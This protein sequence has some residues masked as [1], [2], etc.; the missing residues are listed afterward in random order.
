MRGRRVLVPLVVGTLA[1]GLFAVASP[2]RSDQAPSRLVDRTFSCEAAYVGGV[3][4][5]DV[6]AH[7]RSGRRGSSWRQPAFASVST[8]VSGSAETVVRNELAW[9]TSGRPSADA[10]IA[11]TIPGFTFP[12]RSWGTL[13]FNVD[14]CRSSRARVG[15][16]RAG[17]R[18]GAAGPTD[19]RWD[20]TSGRRVLVRIRAVLTA[21][22]RLTTS[23]GFLRT[24][25]PVE[26]AA[27]AVQASSGKRLVLSQVLRSGRALQYTSPTCFPD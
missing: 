22:S 2:A 11:Q 10:T 27:L 21:A 3:R 8:T 24:T 19:D 26:S 18:G 5:I 23:R 6:R 9:I 1:A 16:S 17:L 4:Q 25:V 7:S 15:L 13:A 14:R 12:F 20:C